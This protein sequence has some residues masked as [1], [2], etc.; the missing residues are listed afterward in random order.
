MYTAMRY[1][2][3]ASIFSAG[4]LTASNSLAEETVQEKAMVVSAMDSQLKW[5]PC[6]AFIPA[7][8]E[9]AVLHG[10]PESDNTDVFFKVPGDFKI[11][12]H[13]HNSPERMVLISGELEVTY[14]GQDTAV[15][16]AGE[17]AYG[18]ARLPHEACCRKGGPCV[19]FI[20]FVS[21]I[22]AMPIEQKQ[23]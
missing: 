16:K 23:D 10:N 18:P 19:L 4:I 22:D 14:D 12:G 1:C 8:C 3:A 6:P 5:G 17:Y 21:P 11:P 9:I 15:M 20:A 7:G 2:V 13:W